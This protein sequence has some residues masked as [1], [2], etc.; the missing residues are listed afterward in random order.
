MC[1]VLLFLLLFIAKSFLAMNN[2]ESSFSCEKVLFT[3]EQIQQAKI[4]PLPISVE[5]PYIVSQGAIYVVLCSHK[6]KNTYAITYSGLT[7][8]DYDE[9]DNPT[10][11]FDHQCQ[12][13]SI[14]KINV[15]KSEHQN[16][17][18]NCILVKMTDI[19]GEIKNMKEE[20]KSNPFSAV[21]VATNL[22]EMI[23]LDAW[24][25]SNMKRLINQNFDFN[26]L[27]QSSNNIPLKQFLLPKNFQSPYQSGQP[28]LRWNQVIFN[29]ILLIWSYI[30]F[31]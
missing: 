4:S 22:N 21:K 26:S 14:T 25:V 29:Y 13:Y 8:D 10:Y 20:Q 3:G 17:L 28:K 27:N 1:I 30:T 11:L 24:F 15:K 31:W 19:I 5:I 6:D 12:Q 23:V 18:S 9:L 16:Y 2:Q 7:Y